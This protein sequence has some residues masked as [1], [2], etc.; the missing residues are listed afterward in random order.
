MKGMA[1]SCRENADAR[2]FM[3]ILMIFVVSRV[4]FALLV[5]VYNGFAGTHHS[6]SFLMNEWDAKKYQF[7]IDNGYTFPTDIDPQANWAFFPLYPIVCM[8]VKRLTLGMIDT[9]WVGMLVSNICIL[10][11]AFYGV[12]L[13]R[14]MGVA[15][16]GNEKSQAKDIEERENSENMGDKGLLLAVFMLA[17][18]YAFYACAVYTESM[19]IMF[20]VL[21]FYC[22]MKRKY[23]L[24]GLMSALASG[25]RIVGCTLVFALLIEMYIDFVHRQK[26]EVDT[27]VDMVWK[28]FISGKC[29]WSFV[30]HLLGTPERLVALFLCPFGTFAY[31]LFLRFFCGDPWAFKNVQI[32]WR[33]DTFSPIIEV[34]WK[35]CTGQI[36]PRYTYMGWICVAV[37]AVYGYMIYRKM[38]AM[39]IFG[40]IALLIPLT[41]HVMS[42]CR[43][44]VGTFVI[45][46]GLYDLLQRSPKPVRIPILTIMAVWETVLIFMWYHSSSWL[47]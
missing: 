28:E 36:E 40:I 7:I 4:F 3:Q 47:L 39:A 10:I 11:A 32:A 43:F 26:C 21:F 6:F 27:S 33:E 18:P 16:N 9:Y 22:A 13:I 5:P 45:F 29:L 8:I 37:F 31:M 12:K 2:L 19:F 30:K 44:I 41:S 38:Y 14:L 17:G 46:V 35:A 42:T 34:M 1:K 24:A 23:M 20:I 15:K 25:T